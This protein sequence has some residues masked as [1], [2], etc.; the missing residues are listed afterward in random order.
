M[1]ELAAVDSPRLANVRVGWF[2]ALLAA[3]AFAVGTSTFALTG[4]LTAIARDLD[5][6]IGSAGLTVTVYAIAS[7][8]G[9]PVL[10]A[11]LGG[12]A[13]MRTLS[14]SIG[15]FGLFSL[16][17]AGAPSLSWL[18]V[19]RVFA[20]LA[21]GVYLSCAA[22]AAARALPAHRQGRAIATVVG[23]ASVATIVG[24]PLGILV[25]LATTWRMVFV[26]VAVLSAV[27]LAGLLLSRV[28]VVGGAPPAGLSARLRPLRRSWVIA[29]ILTVTFLA[30]TASN[31]LL[32]Y[33]GPLLAPAQVPGGL[34]L[35]IAV[36]GVGG[37]A[38]TAWGGI[39]IDRWGG[40]TT[41]LAALVLATIVFAAT[42]LVV[43]NTVLTLIFMFAWGFAVWLCLPAQQHRLLGI[44]SE[45]GP[46]VVALNSSAMNMGFAVGSLVGGVVVDGAGAGSLW[47]VAT[48]VCLVALVLHAGFRWRT[49]GRRV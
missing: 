5:V 47:I 9:V 34:G 41:T 7:A 19:M 26:L 12:T 17:A 40:R 42:W 28:R 6:S 8:V 45:S 46:L 23:G 48:I 1:T 33:L 3:G 49:A 44:D 18:L 22:A 16:C 21:A 11:I 27:P 43:A 25:G 2:V 39:C 15:L 20:A 10:S 38:G 30:F 24:A 29:R 37:L 35:A 14:V 32:T 36:F 13:L 31:V 4:V